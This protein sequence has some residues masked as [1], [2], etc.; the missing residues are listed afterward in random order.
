[1]ALVSLFPPSD[2]YLA[3]FPQVL[4]SSGCPPVPNPILESQELQW[5][6]LFPR[7]PIL[8]LPKGTLNPS[9]LQLRCKET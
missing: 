5:F 7:M 3:A 4:V 9:L 1:M 8:T 6:S 2:E